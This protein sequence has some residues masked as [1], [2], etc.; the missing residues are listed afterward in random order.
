VTGCVGV[1]SVLGGCV[2]LELLDLTGCFHVSN[3]SLSAAVDA[4]QSDHPPLTMYLGGRPPTLIFIDRI[5]LCERQR[6]TR[7]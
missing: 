3:T 2:Q 1:T 4:I 6:A 7:P 5:M